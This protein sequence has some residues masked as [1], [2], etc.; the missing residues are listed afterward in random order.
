MLRTS[1]LL[2]TRLILN[3]WLVRF[4]GELSRIGMLILGAILCTTFH[5]T[6]KI[7]LLLLNWVG[8]VAGELW[9]E[10]SVL[11]LLLLLLEPWG[12][13]SLNSCRIVLAISAHRW[14]LW[15]SG[16]MSRVADN[17]WLTARLF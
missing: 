15:H 6:H 5:S 14:L 11:V 10:V 1:K 12:V 16:L 9:L 3:H 13:H 2:P 8:L 17:F 4:I 7:L